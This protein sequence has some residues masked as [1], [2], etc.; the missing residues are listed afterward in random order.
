MSQLCQETKSLSPLAMSG[1]PDFR[2]W[3]LR[4]SC[5]TPARPARRSIGVQGPHGCLRP[6][7]PAKWGVREGPPRFLQLPRHRFQSRLACCRGSREEAFS[8][9]QLCWLGAAR[10]LNPISILTPSSQTS[11]CLKS[12]FVQRARA[13]AL[14]V[15]PHSQVQVS[16]SSFTLTFW[17]V[18][19]P[20]VTVHCQ[21]T[22]CY[23]LSLQCASQMVF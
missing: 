6:S 12:H 10:Q 7:R 8:Y 21:D 16:R 3:L 1:L 15:C 13:D 22:T 14:T 23:E 5:R 2:H 11:G 20:E 19:L 18:P 17:N 9:P 4:P